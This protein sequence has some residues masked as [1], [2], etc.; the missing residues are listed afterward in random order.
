M[1]TDSTHEKAKKQV[2]RWLRHGELSRARAGT[3]LQEKGFETLV[4]ERV[5]DELVEAGVLDDARCAESLV[6]AWCRSGPMAAR[7]LERRLLER[8]IDACLASSISTAACSDE[9]LEDALVLAR[10]RLGRL[11]TLP[12]NVA[13][14]R[15]FEDLARR[16]YEED[17]ARRTLDVL[18]LSPEED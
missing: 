8:G 9:E 5:L 12:R 3:R 6:N 15:L 13:A 2:L 7:E 18:G 17:T 1:M 16:G 11:G 4:I 10:K 14:R